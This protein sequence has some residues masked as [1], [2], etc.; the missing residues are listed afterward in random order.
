[1]ARDAVELL[2][3]INGTWCVESMGVNQGHTVQSG[4]LGGIYIAWYCGM[5][6]RK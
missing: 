1:V 5:C 2:N 4:L 6:E 3:E